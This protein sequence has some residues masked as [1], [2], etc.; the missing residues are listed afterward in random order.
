MLSRLRD[1]AHRE[2]L[3]VLWSRACC[4]IPAKVKDKL[5]QLISP[6]TKRE[7]QC[8][9]G[10]SIFHHWK[11]ALIYLHGKVESTSFW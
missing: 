1:V 3:G 10:D 5:L 6:A 7:A 9:K 8:L 4:I 2:I 11:T